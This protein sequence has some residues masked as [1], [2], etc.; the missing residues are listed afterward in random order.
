MAE[1]WMQDVG[2]GKAE[3]RLHRALGIPEDQEIPLTR[4]RAATKPDRT[5]EGASV[6][7]MANAALNMRK[8]AKQRIKD[9]VKDREGRK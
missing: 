9:G 7:K 2:R 5:F 6:A 4:L 1:K 8:T 3:G